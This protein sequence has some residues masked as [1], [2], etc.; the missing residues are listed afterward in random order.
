MWPAMKFDHG[1]IRSLFAA[2]IVC[3]I[4]AAD[5][6]ADP[7]T[8]FFEKKIRPVLVER[9]YKCHS[10]QPGG[11]KGGLRLDSREAVRKGGDSGAAVIPG[12]LDDSLLWNAIR[13][14]GLEMPPDGKLSDAT[15]ADFEKWIKMGAPDPRDGAPS[16]TEPATTDW[17][18][19]RQFWSFQPPSR[20]PAPVLKSN[21]S[22]R[23]PVDAFVLA[24][25]ESA[26]LEPNPEADR[27]TLIRRV[28][29][30]LIG[31]PPT[32]DDV[33]SF[34]LDDHP[35]AYER[36]VDRI[37]ASPQYG[38]RWARPWLDLARYAEDQAHIVGNDREL[39]YPNAY[40]YRDWVVAALNQDLPYD[41]FVK[42]QLAA[43]LLDPQNK[44]G[45]AALGFLG[46]GPK[47][48]RRN[49]PEVMADEWEDRVDIV[50]RGLLGLTVACAR[51]HDHKFDPIPT[52]DYYALAGVFAS[53]EMYNRPFDDKTEL[54]KNGQAK[55]P[56]HSMHIVRDINI[57]DIPVHIR[58]D[59]KNKGPVIHRRF[60]QVLSTTE[61]PPFQRG[62]GRLDLADAIADRQNPLTARVIVNRIWAQLFGRALVAT[63]SNFGSLGEKP[64]HPELLDDLAVRFMDNGWSLK[65]LQRELVLSNTYRQSSTS[66][67]RKQGVDPANVLLWRM[68]RRRLSIEAW[69]DTVLSIAGQ[70]DLRM[71]GPSFDPENP[72]NGRRTMYSEVSRLKLNPLLALFDFPDPNAHSER[73]SETTTPLQKLFVLNSPFMVRQAELLAARLTSVSGDD[74]ARIRSAYNDVFARA[75]TSQE[76]R[77]GEEFLNGCGEGDASRWIQFA[78]VLLASNELFMID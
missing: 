71:G 56:Q 77:L 34:V 4:A 33:E 39:C 49:A 13:Y 23:Q 63:P 7:G 59:A 28:S 57:Q 36:L 35:L 14:E 75:P 24:K 76:I 6:V 12:K 5:V 27:R 1:P 31:L 69:R 72:G 2:M 10:D 68:N 78:Q 74:A 47:Y 50:S 17:N 53:T 26:G 25:L 65:A 73:R 20:Y 37:L 43:D 18:A 58:G 29:F 16:V 8:E 21:Q 30:D 44:A 19:A 62:S 3:G 52:Q 40:L 54:G 55:D 11:V 22:R 67:A 70:L 60:L 45:H 41:Q 15:I 66:D 38:E 9:C 48:Y 46:L 61:P 42:Q 51:C 64:S 32:A